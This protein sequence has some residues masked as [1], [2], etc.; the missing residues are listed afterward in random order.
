M[1]RIRYCESCRIYTLKEIC[2]ICGGST[3]LKAPLRYSNDEQLKKYRRDLKK[4]EI[5]R[6][7]A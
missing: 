2:S 3:V 6:A 4:E 7:S 5:G 1:K